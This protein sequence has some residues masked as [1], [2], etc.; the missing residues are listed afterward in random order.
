MSLTFDEIILQIRKNNIEAIELLFSLLG[1]HFAVLENKFK[2]SGAILG[3][4]KQDLR[5]IMQKETMDVVKLYEFDK[6]NFFAYWKLIIS[7]KFYNI[8]E[9]YYSETTVFKNIINIDEV[10]ELTYDNGENV[11]EKQTLHDL[12]NDCLDI[13]HTKS[14]DDAQKIIILWSEGYSYQEISKIMKISNNKVCYYIQK[15]IKLLRDTFKNN[16]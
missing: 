2:S 1:K 8:F 9:S 11:L 16:L 10:F 13:I 12:Y 7:R 4:T 15:T 5:M 14:G 6:S 3:Y